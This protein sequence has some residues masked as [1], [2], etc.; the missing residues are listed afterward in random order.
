MKNI[1]K[2]TFLRCGN[3]LLSALLLVVCITSSV[4]TSQAQIVQPIYSFPL[5]GEYPES[6]LTLGPDSNF[7]GTTSQG[8]SSGEGTVFR[9]TTNGTLTTLYSFSAGDENNSGYYTNSDGAQPSAAL[10]LGPDGNF[11]GTTQH[12][13]TNG[14]GTVFEVTSDGVL[15]T[16]HSFSALNSNYG[17]TDGAQP[18]AALTLGLDGNFYGTTQSGGSSGYG[19]AFE[20][21]TNGTLTTLASFANTNGANPYAGLTLGPD[22][23]FY[24][25]TESGGSS[26]YGTVFKVTTNGVLTT[27]YSFTATIFDG[28]SYQYT[29]SDGEQPQASL[30]PGPD[31]NFYG[32]TAYGGDS[33]YGTVFRVTTSGALTTLVSFASTNGA[34]PYAGLA[35][36]PDSNFYGTTEYGGS[37]GEGTVFRVTANGILTSLYS[38]ATV[39]DGKGNALDGVQPQA[40]LAPGPDGN[41]YGTTYQGGSSGSYGTV[42][43][44]TTNGVLSTLVNLE[45]A[46]NGGDPNALTLG[47]DGN[48]YGTTAGGGSSGD[49]TV[50]EARTNGVLTTLYS[51]SATIYNGSDGFTNADGGTPYA[52]LALGPDGNL[53]GTTS[54]GGSNGGGTVFK[55]TTN[56]VLTTLFSF[57][58][59]IYNGNGNYTNADGAEPYAGLTLGPDGNFYGTTASGG[60]SG[61]GTV[62]EV[63]TNGTL[64]TLVSVANTNG[65]A[66][67]GLTLGLDGNFY[68]TTAS[69]GSGGDGTVFRVTTHGVL[70][71]LTNIASPWAG[72]L[73][74]GSLSFGLT[75]GPDGNF[76]GTTFYGGI[77]GWGTVFKVTTNGVL[78]TLYSF[79]G[80]NDGGDPASLTLGP[81]RKLYGITAGEVNNIYGTIFQM[82]TNGTLTTLYTFTNYDGFPYAAPTLGPDGYFYG[83]TGENGAEAGEIYRMDISPPIIINEPAS[84][85]VPI[86]DA[87]LY[88]VSAI[89]ALPLSYQW[90]F[91]TNTLLSSATNAGLA[92]SPAIANDDGYYQVVVSNLF[93][94]ATSDVASLTVLVE[95]NMW[96][97][98]DNPSGGFTTLSLASYPGSTN[99]LYA[100]TDLALPLSQWQLIATNVAAPNGLFQFI[101]TNTM[102]VPAKFYRLSDQLISSPI[103]INSVSPILPEQT[104]TITISGSGFGTQSPYNGDSDYLYILD[105]TGLWQ[106]GYLPAGNDVTLNVTSWTANQIV[107]SGFTGYYGFGYWTLEPGDNLTIAVWNPQTGVGPATYSVTVEP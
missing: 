72:D 76:Y 21:T 34:N 71:T 86:G 33:G 91:N 107:I 43:Q 102:G 60:N 100:T 90:C 74:A 12:G 58:A 48:F 99:Y 77:N 82:T 40:S 67:A 57:S 8:G 59:A 26:G 63:T 96:G 16:I 84:E 37:D 87:A 54:G 69:G 65:Y 9:V 78:T 62:F 14:D 2:N 73:N 22:G 104:Q 53:Y 47:P 56:G 38:F 20:V 55:V 79:T 81:G 64:T 4:S 27:L 17:N 50:F 42:F 61:G 88:Q 41:F 101:D 36:G 13:G 3:C 11:Y 85:T 32:T 24:G 23:N 92:I 1:S 10:T 105:N 45:S 30:T 83:T 39:Q 103:L 15:T 29:N 89:G 106:A 6:A 25:T 44:V 52:A 98:S 46:P 31:G 75:L 66:Y 49:G 18:S 70:T 80:G 94:S 19:T 97:I 68:G 7:Y 51:F 93:G 5:G 28:S 35:P 95:P